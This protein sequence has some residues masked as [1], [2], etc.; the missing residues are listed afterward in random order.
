MGDYVHALDAAAVLTG[1][2][3]PT[4]WAQR[5]EA[6]L[7]A[8]RG[9]PAHRPERLRAERG[10]SGCTRGGG[11]V[12]CRIGAARMAGEPVGIGPV[13]GWESRMRGREARL[14]SVAFVE[15]PDGLGRWA[16]GLVLLRH[17]RGADLRRDVVAGVVL[18]ALLV[19]QGMAYAQLAGLPP[20]TGLYA[21]LVPLVVYFLLGPSRI[22]VLGPDS[23][24]VS[25]RRRGDHPA[26]GG[27]GRVGADRARRPAR[28]PRRFD[29]ARGRAGALRLRDRT[30]VDARAPWL[31]HG[32]RRDR[33]RRAA[34]EA[35]R[36]LGR[37]GEL[38]PGGARLRHGTRR[39]QP[40]R[41]R[42]RR[43]VARADPRPASG[44]AEGAGCLRRGRRRDG[45]GRGAGSRR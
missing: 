37:R 16:P 21:T 6:W 41:A 32:H 19:P 24:V 42:D 25:A 17:R 45:G 44:R 12:G 4:E 35:L 3:V 8:A 22:L 38:P 7:V 13:L 5:L 11:A 26:G 29:H 14:V 43:R 30:A 36:V 1:G 23:A 9:E 15:R 20:V 39:D 18:A 33:H 2:I 28:D 40:D 31:P 34:P 27:R 10:A